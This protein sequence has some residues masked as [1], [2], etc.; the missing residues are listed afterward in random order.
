M[1]SGQEKLSIL[2]AMLSSGEFHHA[3][4]RCQGSLWEGLWI[5]PR[6]P[7]GFRG[8]GAPTLCFHAGT[9]ELPEAEKLCQGTGI[10]V[11]AYGV[12]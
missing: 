2:R 12:G 7:N 11:G 1:Q 6:D 9:P 5:Y 4:Y 8:Y 3:T 10:S